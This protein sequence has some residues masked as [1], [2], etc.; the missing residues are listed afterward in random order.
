MSSAA[1]SLSP[2][3]YVECDVPAG[4]TL[5][6]WRRRRNESGGER[7]TWMS[8]VLRRVRRVRRARR[9]NEAVAR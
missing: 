1:L 2:V 7:V 5:T 3:I 8:G 9:H 6:E 4:M